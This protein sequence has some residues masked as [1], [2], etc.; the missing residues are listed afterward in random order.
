[1]DGAKSVAFLLYFQILSA[2]L[3]CE[4]SVGCNLLRRVRL[5]LTIL[6]AFFMPVF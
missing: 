1:M 6:R 5:M 4:T 2:Y 3:Q